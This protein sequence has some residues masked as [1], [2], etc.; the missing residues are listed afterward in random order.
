MAYKLYIATI[1]AGLLASPAIAQAPCAPSDEMRSLVNDHL[2]QVIIWRGLS[3][4]G[5]PTEIWQNPENGT[6]TALQ[7]R[8]DGIGCAVSM[9]G[10]GAI[11]DVQ[12]GDPA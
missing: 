11:T 3:V 7:H 6:W 8:P 4:E 9:G 1:A 5:F 12:I 2:G 10:L